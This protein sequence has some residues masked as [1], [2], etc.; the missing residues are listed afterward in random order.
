MEKQ[1]NLR[2]HRSDDEY[3]LKNEKNG[4]QLKI[5]STVP[6]QIYLY[7]PEPVL[8]VTFCSPFPACKDQITWIKIE[9]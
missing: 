5:P 7:Q 1:G 8:L 3:I 2:H 4:S 6:F 9:L